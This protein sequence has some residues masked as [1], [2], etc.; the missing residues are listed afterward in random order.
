[1]EP[2]NTIID[3]DALRRN[4]SGDRDLV[5]ELIEVFQQ[6]L[7]KIQS[8]ILAS[9]VSG[10][11]NAISRSAHKLKGSLLVLGAR[12][13]SIAERLELQARDGCGSAVHDLSTELDMK[14]AQVIPAL[15]TLM[16]T[17]EL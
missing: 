6:E 3:L 9:R 14:V 16:Q 10:D 8:V 4:T 11:G 5:S 12:C 7:P 13:A 2:I 1:M 17:G 15:R